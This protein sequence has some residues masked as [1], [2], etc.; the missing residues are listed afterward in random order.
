MRIDGIIWLEH[1]VEKL[2]VKHW[3]ATE[4]VEEVLSGARSFRRIERG[5]V[6]GEDV[7]AT[8]RQTAAGRHL[9][10]SLCTSAAA[11]HW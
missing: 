1:I 4:E 5:D 9:T 6:A 2:A 8:V 11:R 3:V 7:Y 10:C